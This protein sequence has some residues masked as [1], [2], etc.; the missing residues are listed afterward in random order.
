MHMYLALTQAGNWLSSL[1]KKCMNNLRRD[2]R[3]KLTG[4]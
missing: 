2:K 1:Q 4:F 3:A